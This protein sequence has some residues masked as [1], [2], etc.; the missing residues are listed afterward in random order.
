[1]KILT[2]TELNMMLADAKTDFSDMLFD[3]LSFEEN[4]DL[5]LDLMDTDVVTDGYNFDGSVFQNM[6][7]CTNLLA[8]STFKGTTIKKCTVQDDG[9]SECDFTD[10]I[11]DHVQFELAD[12]V[13]REY[14]MKNKVR[15][16]LEK[17]SKQDDFRDFDGSSFVNAKITHT[18]FAEGAGR[19]DFTGATITKSRFTDC[20]YRSIVFE[21][22]ILSNVMIRNCEFYT[23]YCGD[24]KTPAMECSGAAFENITLKNV[25][26]SDL[27]IHVRPSVKTIDELLKTVDDVTAKGIGNY[28]AW[29]EE[30]ESKTR[31]A[32]VAYEND[33]TIYGSNVMFDGK[34]ARVS[35]YDERFLCPFMEPNAYVAWC[36]KTYNN[37]PNIFIEQDRTI[38]Q[39][40]E[41]YSMGHHSDGSRVSFDETLDWLINAGVDKRVAFDL[42]IENQYHWAS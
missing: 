22:A 3:G 24:G 1:M 4:R 25:K 11:I 6:Q 26:V 29:L 7:L 31:F 18:T 19:H 40:I 8:G 20:Y 23:L 34:Y 21:N 39:A 41:I 27:H 9:I 14:H 13:K 10:A 32:N 5:I 28:N 12:Y 42:V 17:Q 33:K 38:E 35:G 16:I 15:P 30:Q 36:E 37:N 2:Q